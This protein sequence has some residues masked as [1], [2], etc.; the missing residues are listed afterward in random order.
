MEDGRVFRGGKITPRD[1]PVAD[2]FCH[3]GDQLADTGFA[4]AKLTLR[5][6]DV[7][8]QVLG[9]DDVGRG[10]RP[11]RGNLDVFLLEDRPPGGVGDGSGAALPRNLAIG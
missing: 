2:G 6:A 8:V 10:H 11:I 3:P 4:S 9:S 7:T 1:T 5:S